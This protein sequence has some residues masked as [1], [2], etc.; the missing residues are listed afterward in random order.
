[1]NAGQ[2]KTGGGFKVLFW[3]WRR[4]GTDMD[5]RT[6]FCTRTPSSIVYWTGLRLGQSMYSI[7]IA[8]PN[9][10]HCC[11]SLSLSHEHIHSHNYI[12]FVCVY[13][14]VHYCCSGV[15]VTWNK[16]IINKIYVMRYCP[17]TCMHTNP[18]ANNG[19]LL[20]LLQEQLL[21]SSFPPVKFK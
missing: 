13:G 20:R 19:N 14:N 12:F 8:Y 4:F 9:T 2:R 6:V 21:A 18:V 17:C 7:F 15:Y 3:S 10:R 11:Q 16:S 5:H 1:M